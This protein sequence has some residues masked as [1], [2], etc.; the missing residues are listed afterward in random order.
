VVT[1][2]QESRSPVVVAVEDGR[3][4]GLV[5]VAAVNAAMGAN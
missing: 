3:V 4:L 1:A 2:I 5:T